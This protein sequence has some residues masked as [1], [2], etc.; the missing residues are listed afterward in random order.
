MLDPE[1]VVASAIQKYG[2]LSSAG[3]SALKNDVVAP[4]IV[5]M[6]KSPFVLYLEKDLTPGSYEAWSLGAN[7]RGL[8]AGYHIYHEPPGSRL[9]CPA[10]PHEIVAELPAADRSNQA[11]VDLVLRGEPWPEQYESVLLEASQDARQKSCPWEQ[12]E[13]PSG[14]ITIEIGPA[15]GDR[16]GSLQS[17]Q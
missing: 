14:P 6:A 1:A 9:Y 8:S 4:G 10:K 5:G 2:V 16:F 3:D 7:A 13:A 12:P 15:G 11:L 17:A